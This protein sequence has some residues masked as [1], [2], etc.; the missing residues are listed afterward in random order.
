M[1]KDIEKLKTALIGSSLSTVQKK[2]IYPLINKN[3]GEKDSAKGI[4][5]LMKCR[6]KVRK[7]LKE[8]KTLE[9]VDLELKIL[10]YR[11]LLSKRALMFL[12]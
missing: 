3:V 4:V 5:N 12:I 7:I 9:K 8:S 6:N 11:S 2:Q 1:D 10:Y